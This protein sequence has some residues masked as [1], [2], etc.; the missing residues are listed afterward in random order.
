MANEISEN[1][2]AAYARLKEQGFMATKEQT[3]ELKV[4]NRGIADGTNAGSWVID[5]NT[6]DETCREILQQMADC[7]WDG[8]Q[9]QLGE[10]AGEPSF[11]EILDAIGITITEDLPEVVDEL[12][13]VYHDA[14]YGGLHSE[15]ERACLARVTP[16]V[17]DADETDR[18]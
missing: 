6:S 13:N 15:V 3:D 7:E 16:D 9:L 2:K 18:G 17:P 11:E 14:W 1:M 4:H 5:G 12:F 10:W 8:P